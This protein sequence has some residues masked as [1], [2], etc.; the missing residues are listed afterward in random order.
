MTVAIC[1]TAIAPSVT[2]AATDLNPGDASVIAQANGDN[3]RLR[4]APSSSAKVVGS[5]PEGSG[6]QIT[7][8]LVTDAD[9]TAWYPAQI[10][11]KSGFVAAEFV[12]SSDASTPTPAPTPAL[13]PTVLP[14]AVATD[15]PPPSVPTS[16]W[17]FNTNGD[18]IRCRDSASTR[19]AILFRFAAGDAIVLTG[20]A[21]NGWFPVLCGDKVGFVSSDFVTLTQ[22]TATPAITPATSPTDISIP[23]KAAVTSTPV[24]APEVAAASVETGK[25][26]TVSGTNGDGVHCRSAGSLTAAVITV[27]AEGTT[28]ALRGAIGGDWTE[29]TCAGK[30]GW[31]SSQFLSTPASSGGAGGG[32]GSLDGTAATITNSN[33]D[34]V[35]CRD[36]DSYVSNV[37]LVLPEYTKITLRGNQKG[38][39]MPVY[40]SSKGEKGWVFADFVTI[41]A[42]TKPTPTATPAPRPTATPKPTPP[43]ASGAADGFHTGDA[44]VVANT[45]GDG[46]RLRSKASSSASVIMVLPEGS[47]AAVRAG[48]AGDWVEVTYEST[49]GFIFGD[50]LDI[51]GVGGGNPGSTPTPAP[52]TGLHDGDHARVTATLNFRAGASL[53]SSIIGVANAGD[54]VLITGA[55]KNGFYP[56][57]YLRQAGWMGGDY[58][59]FTDADVTAPPLVSGNAGSGPAS[60]QGQ[61]MVD[62]AMKYLGYPYVWAT[63][64]PDTFD[65]SG[66]TY[67]VTL[68]T[69]N[70]DIGA[71]TWLQ[72]DEGTPVQYGDLKPGDLVFFQ[73]T[74]TWGLSHVGIYIGANRFI[75]AE[76]ET[77][78]VKIS[79]LTSPY[80]AS[81]WYGARRIAK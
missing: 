74:Y 15:A 80:Y 78:G 27:V 31:V 17:I 45:N 51:V 19:G 24:S 30:D 46:V 10:A 20:D 11:G 56:V 16:A 26:A 21:A 58:L 36:K 39:W 57:E 35:R 40:C 79:Y 7:G 70:K 52:V 18:A 1:L 76:N 33:G 14:T 72:I 60:N 50:Y 47:T 49:N 9:G 81:R 13:T 64:G 28:L 68:N 44:V 69:L 71:G 54:V 23:K 66:F 29:V 42:V 75:H 32:S 25:S 63:H 73:N 61:A 62:Y 59:T 77:T 34:G 67:W 37:I 48:S 6:V 12:W 4:D 65:C 3:V 5:F 55:A 2:F 38:D 22:P 43:P 53:T 8:A 41:G